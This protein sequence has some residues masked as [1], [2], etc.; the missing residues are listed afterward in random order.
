MEEVSD[1][2]EQ[3]RFKRTLG[4]IKQAILRPDIAVDEIQM[5]VQ[6]WERFRVGNFQGRIS[7][8]ARC[9]FNGRLSYRAGCMSN[10]RET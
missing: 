10:G 8:Q 3:A 1:L 6:S 2:T 7:Q 5:F 9:I 4:K